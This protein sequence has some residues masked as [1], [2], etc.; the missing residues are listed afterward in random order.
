MYKRQQI[1]RRHD[2]EARKEIAHKVHPH[3]GVGVLRH[4]HL[5]LIH[6]FNDLPQS[7]VEELAQALETTP[8]ALL[9]LDTPCATPLKMAVATSA[10]FATTP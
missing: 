8:A 9:G 2:V 10:K 5:S 6:I 3:P 4:L 1:A 7:K